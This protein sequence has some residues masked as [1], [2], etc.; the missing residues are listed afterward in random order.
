MDVGT[1]SGFGLDPARSSRALWVRR[2]E[3]GWSEV[4]PDET[5]NEYHRNVFGEQLMTSGVWAAVVRVCA[6][7]DDKPGGI[8]VGIAP[9]GANPSVPL[10]DRSAGTQSP[11]GVHDGHVSCAHSPFHS[12]VGWGKAMAYV[13][14]T[15]TMSKP[16]KSTRYPFLPHAEKVKCEQRHYTFAYSVAEV[17]GLLKGWGFGRYHINFQRAGIDGLKLLNLTDGLLQTEVGMTD[18]V[19]RADLLGRIHGFFRQHHAFNRNDIV[20]LVLDLDASP[21]SLRLFKKPGGAG[22]WLQV[23]TAVGLESIAGESMSDGKRSGGSCGWRWAVTLNS[24]SDTLHFWSCQ[25]KGDSI[26]VQA[27]V[28]RRPA[29]G[30]EGAGRRQVGLSASSCLGAG[31]LLP[32]GSLDDWFFV[33]DRGRGDYAHVQ[34]LVV[35]NVYTGTVVEI[36]LNGDNMVLL[37]AGLP[38]C[39][40]V[41]CL[42]DPYQVPRANAT[43]HVQSISAHTGAVS[44]SNWRAPHVIQ[45]ALADLALVQNKPE[46]A[47]GKESGGEGGWPRGQGC[48]TVSRRRLG[49]GLAGK[50]LREGIEW[51][52]VGDKASGRASA[53]TGHPAMAGHW[54]CEY[55]PPS[56]TSPPDSGKLHAPVPMLTLKLASEESDACFTV[57]LTGAGLIALV[58]AALAPSGGPGKAVLAMNGM[59]SEMTSLREAYE[60]IA[61]LPLESEDAES[62][63]TKRAA[64]VRPHTSKPRPQT[65]AVVM[66]TGA[67]RGAYCRPAQIRDWLQGDARA[68]WMTVVAQ[69]AAFG[70]DLRVDSKCWARKQV[71]TL[72][73]SFPLC[74][75]DYGA[76]H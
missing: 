31:S 57:C 64:N 54:L 34:F 68:R 65:A 29:R 10:G 49:A 21:P 63:M 24:P 48:T 32:A 51:R 28:E 74:P 35:Y 59:G 25:G 38:T 13:T 20:R 27:K 15:A 8:F 1:V 47:E 16:V 60:S 55:H 52:Q 76:S 5:G 39:S 66:S 23:G 41:G 42:S 67:R 7:K 46:V 3:N 53:D 30:A 26:P 69:P 40:A 22:D 12:G 73:L 58:P 75:I 19:E 9:D 14:W 45:K 11:A 18:G 17:A 36:A 43:R 61:R 62:S 44:S 4:R 56:A 33:L 70:D 72:S 71:L 6:A 2:I 50:R 37:Q